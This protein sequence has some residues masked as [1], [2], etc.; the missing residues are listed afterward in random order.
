MSKRKKRLTRQEKKEVM[1]AI[2][3]GQ[4]PGYQL[5]ENRIILP[6]GESFKVPEQIM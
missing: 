4:L 1:K 6:S 5:V 2:R 3:K